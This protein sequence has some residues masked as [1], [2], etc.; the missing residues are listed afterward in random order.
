M[1]GKKKKTTNFLTDFALVECREEYEWHRNRWTGQYWKYRIVTMETWEAL[2]ADGEAMPASYVNPGGKAVGAWRCE[3]RGL[4]DPF[5]SPLR[6]RYHET[7]ISR[8][9]LNEV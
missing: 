9:V 7:W 8:G 3:D 1:G 5:G 2:L 4:S 6:R